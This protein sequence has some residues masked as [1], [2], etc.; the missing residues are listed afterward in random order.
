M[1]GYWDT[2]IVGAG[3][4]GCVL[5]ARLSEDPARQV[6]LLEAGPDYATEADLPP[7]LLDAGAP[8]WTH[9]WGY[10]SE[11]GALGRPIDLNRA[12]VVGGCSATNAT[13]ALRGNRSDYDRWAALGNPGWGFDDVLAFFRRLETDLDFAA[14]WHGDRGPVRV[15]RYLDRELTTTQKAFLEAC[16]AAGVPAVADHNEPGA[17]GAGPTPVN[18]VGGV[19][20]SA[21]LSYLGPARGRP[22][23]TIWAGQLADAV[24]VDRETV[25]G[26]RLTGGEIL[27]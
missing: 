12:K 11:P 6:L 10:R 15:R 21:A 1:A 14:P 27:G 17:R 20:Q 16:G 26:V 22:N 13:F 25:T 19:R 2:V 8:A 5:A 3:S 4:A 23:L 9:D 18:A 24:V 7:E